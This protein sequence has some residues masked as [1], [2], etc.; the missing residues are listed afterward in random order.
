MERI[1]TETIRRA[2]TQSPWQ[3]GKVYDY[4][5]DRWRQIAKQ[6][7]KPLDAFT[8]PVEGPETP[9]PRRP[10]AKAK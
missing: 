5:L 10:G 9:S 6:L 8:R 3:A 4:P 7:R 2:P 1:F